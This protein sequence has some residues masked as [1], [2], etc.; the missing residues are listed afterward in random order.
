MLLREDAVLD[1]RNSLSRVAGLTVASASDFSE[2]VAGPPTGAT[3]LVFEDLGVAVV[4]APPDQAAAVGVAVAADTGVL[5]YEPERVV[6]A[7]GT[8]WGYN[9]PLLVAPA[10]RATT[11]RGNTCV[12]TRTRSTFSST[13]CWRRAGRRPGPP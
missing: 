1:A 10:A 3:A 7:I 13:R 6:H 2:P 8:G 12:A 4:D 9:V 5:A 11:P